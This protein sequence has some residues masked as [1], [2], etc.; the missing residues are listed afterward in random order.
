MFVAD[1][2]TLE[3]SITDDTDWPSPLLIA[4]ISMMSVM[5]DR[6]LS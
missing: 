1:A 3:L 4:A 2:G 5:R 6:N